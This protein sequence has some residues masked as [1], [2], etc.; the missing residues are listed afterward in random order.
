MADAARAIIIE[1]DKMLLMHRNKDGNEYFTLVGG[2][3]HEQEAPEHGLAREVKEETGL[4]VTSCR[5][6]YVEDHPAPYNRQYIFLCQVAPH[7]AIA[8]QETSEEALLNKISTNLHEPL[9]IA[10]SSFP[11][12]S[13]LTMQLQA[14]IVTALK[15]GF[16]ET[17]IKL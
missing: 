9:W 2:R 13:F 10:V 3:I 8:I 1:N 12:L 16:P 14:A 7:S 17:P 11:K 5:L 4:D 15:K 6:V